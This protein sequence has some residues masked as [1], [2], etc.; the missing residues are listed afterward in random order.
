MSNNSQNLDLVPFVVTKF[1]VIIMESFVVNP[2]KVFSN[3]LF[4]M[5]NGI[6]AIIRIPAR[7]VKLM[8]LPGRSVLLVDFLSVW[9]KV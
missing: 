1:L 4:K 8:W 2:A 9:T 7:F 6:H 5:P 3:G